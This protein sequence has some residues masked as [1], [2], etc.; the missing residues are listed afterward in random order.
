MLQSWREILLLLFILVAVIQ[1]FYYLYFFRRLA[2]YKEKKNGATPVQGVSII[3]SARN[4]ELNLANNLPSV[5]QQEFHSPTEVIVVNDNSTDNSAAVLNSLISRFSHFKIINMDG[6]EKSLAGKKIP[7]SMGIKESNND[8][9]LL[10]DADC[11]P[12]SHA[13]LTKMMKPFTN[14]IEIVLGYGAYKKEN[15]FLNKLIRFETFHTAIQYLSFAL[16]GKPYMGV[17]RNLAYRRKVFEKAG[18]FSSIS[19]I[20]GG[21]DDLFI[22]KVANSKNT[23]ITIDPDAFTYS[24]PKRTWK[25]WMSQKSRHYSV[26]KYYRNSDKFLLGLYTGS[27]FVFYLLLIVC[28][29]VSDYRVAL[30]VFFT[31]L[32]VVGIIWN[33]AMK[34][35][36]EQD[37]FPLFIFWDVFLF[38]YY[39][40]FAPVLLKKPGKSWN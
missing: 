36:K 26:S 40:V 24:E 32:I 34:R 10:T 8:F 22:N 15:S 14:E 9:L 2:F 21:D 5:L 28:L 29:F 38:V 18:G 25:D 11:V 1:L 3:I 33:K 4:E 31:R 16:A 37:L 20:A 13:W 23:A 7:L 35:L 12:A 39:L 17:G 19:Q 30:F 27:H 6:V